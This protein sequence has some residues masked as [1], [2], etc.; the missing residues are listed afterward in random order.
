[1]VVNTG[2]SGRSGDL[3]VVLGGFAIG[4]KAHIKFTLSV[5]V[6]VIIVV[7]VVQLHLDILVHPEVETQ[8]IGLGGTAIDIAEVEVAVLITGAKLD[9]SPIMSAFHLGVLASVGVITLFSAEEQVAGLGVPST[10]IL[11]LGISGVRFEVDIVTNIGGLITETI[12]VT[13]ELD[14]PQ[15]VVVEAGK[16]VGVKILLAVDA[17]GVTGACPVSPPLAC[18]KVGSGCPVGIRRTDMEAGVVQLVE[19]TDNQA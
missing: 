9:I 14:G 2:L 3:G 11:G 15:V 10:E 16:V 5:G 13:G 7:L 19:R 1:M 12:P 17:R 18:C 8:S 6:T 4:I